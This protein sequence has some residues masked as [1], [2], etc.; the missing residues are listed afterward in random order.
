MPPTSWREAREAAP[1]RCVDFAGDFDR[2]RGRSV[3]CIDE[4]A[5]GRGL[6]R[7]W[8][9]GDQEARARRSGP[10]A[11]V[12][13]INFISVGLLAAAPI[14]ALRPQPAAEPVVIGSVAGDRGREEQFRVRLG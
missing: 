10:C 2:M 9:L 12:I 4:A 11:R 1:I 7:L 3:R 6:D 5:S 14:R 13:E 8:N